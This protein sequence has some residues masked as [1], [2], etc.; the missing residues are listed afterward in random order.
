MKLTSS[1]INVKNE[2]IVCLCV[3][4]DC[5]S[6]TC[7]ASASQQAPDYRLYKSEPELTTVNEEGDEA[8]VEDK[9]ETSA[10][11]KDAAASK[12]DQSR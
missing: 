8:A 4:D 10:E 9:M 6:L 11:S 5:V 3:C 7:L 1:Q 2:S 12:G